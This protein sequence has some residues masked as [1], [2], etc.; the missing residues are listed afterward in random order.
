MKSDAHTCNAV[1][2]SAFTLSEL[3]VVISIIAVLMAL[4]LP[5]IQNARA[6]SRRM[7]CLDHVRQLGL[8]LHAFAAKDPSGNFPPYG[9]VGDFKSGTSWSGTAGHLKSWVVDILPELDRQDLYDRWD[10]DRKHDS[11]TKG[12]DGISNR[13]LT[14][15]YLLPVLTCPA[16]E[17]AF[18]TPGSLS[19]VVNAGY[20]NL[21][22]TG[23]K[24]P[25]QMLS[26]DT[27]WGGGANYHNYD[28]PDLD[29]NGNGT[30]NDTEDI[31]I[32]H[33]T[34]VMWRMV[35][36]RDGDGLPTPMVNRSYGPN[37]IYDGTSN[38]ILA[39]EN[40]NAGNTDLWGDPDPRNCTFVYPLDWDLSDN[41]PPLDATNYLSTAP[42]DPDHSYGV[43]NESL[44]G[45][46]GER[47]FPNSK[48]AGVVNVVFCDGSARPISEDINLSVYARIIT[49]AAG[50]RSGTITPQTPLNGN[51]F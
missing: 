16:D 50:R 33:T 41:T 40:I 30:T 5:A 35:L 29:L 23:A 24:T 12:A 47:P 48:H 42:L 20:A 8:A 2:R 51:S 34:G 28:D 19:Y 27:G 22:P 49:P 18:S 15:L 3:L 17:S 9:T 25:A 36:D 14:Q 43:I 38:T 26:S 37:N 6:T 46:D 21:K 13:D 4:L 32:H 11:T 7:Q 1:P 10:H 39:T 31:N 45:P 44:D